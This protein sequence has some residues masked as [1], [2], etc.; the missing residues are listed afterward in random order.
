MSVLDFPLALKF[1]L[2]DEGGLDDDPHDH[3]GRT[4]HGIIQREY[5]AYRARKGEPKQDV[6]KIN[7]QEV[8]EIY[9]TSYWEPWCDKLPGGLD[10]V[11]FDNAVNTGP[12]Q[13]IK[14]LQK[15]LGVPA[16]GHMNITTLQEIT[17]QAGPKLIVD[18]CNARRS[19]Y[20]GLK[21][22]S[23]YGKG[24]LARVD[25]VQKLAINLEAKTPGIHDPLPADLQKLATAR[26]NP[27]DV[28]K[29]LLPSIAAV[30]A[31]GV[32]LVV[33]AVSHAAYTHQQKPL[34]KLPMCEAAK[35]APFNPNSLIIPAPKEKVVHAVQPNPRTHRQKRR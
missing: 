23:R 9:Q 22:F 29:P 16:D 15:V 33:G 3:G 32:A 18:Y 8:S 13:A 1:V 24:W 6:W 30:V 17:D 11:F 21:Q 31:G 26:A 34:P 14:T 5:D 25:H 4:A 10:Y 35:P 12:V 28:K 19:F 27:D 20:K 2:L 7:S